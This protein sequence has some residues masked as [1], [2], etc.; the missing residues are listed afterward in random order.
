M[1]PWVPVAPLHQACLQ[2]P[3]Q[4]ATAG[5]GLQQ[6]AATFTRPQSRA[7]S[8]LGIKQDSGSCCAEAQTFGAAKAQMQGEVDPGVGVGGTPSPNGRETTPGWGGQI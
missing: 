8:Q 1:E 2:V 4:A 5:G 7:L 3:Q 6:Q